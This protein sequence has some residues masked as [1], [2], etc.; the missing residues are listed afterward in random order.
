MQPKII[1]F[2]SCFLAVIGDMMLTWYAKK[3]GTSI[4]VFIAAFIIN[5][6][7]IFIWTYSMK[8]GIEAATAITVYA[9]FT[10]MACS[11]LGYG[12]F[13]ETLTATNLVGIILAVI[14]L[15]LMSI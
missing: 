12:I 7:G 1:L 15:I 8:K 5:A 4:W 10:V 6:L 2:L 3:N 14:S 9:V 13:G 11:A